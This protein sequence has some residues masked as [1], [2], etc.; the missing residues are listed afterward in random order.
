LAG[1][2]AGPLTSRGLARRQFYGDRRPLYPGHHVLLFRCPPTALGR[3]FQA[4]A[5]ALASGCLLAGY[6]NRLGG[7]ST[8]I[9]WQGHPLYPLLPL[10]LL[11]GSGLTY[12][13]SSPLYYIAGQTVA[14]AACFL[15]LDYAVRQWQSPAGAFLNI[16]AFTV[17]GAWSYSLYLWQE[18]F[19]DYEPTGLLIPFPLNLVFTLA[20]ALFSYYCI[21]RVF[22]GLRHR[23]SR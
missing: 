20:A 3:H 17:I 7:L 1:P 15:L 19:L 23:F 14:N 10:V 4:I 2:V 22:F 16:R 11:A 21:E 12:K 8:Y 9:R 13:I 18:L 6:Y 5:D